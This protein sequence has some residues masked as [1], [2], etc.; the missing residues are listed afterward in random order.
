MISRCFQKHQS[1]KKGESFPPI[2]KRFSFYHRCPSWFKGRRWQF[3]FLCAWDLLRGVK[4]GG[5]WSESPSHWLF[6]YVKPFN[7]A[8]QRYHETYFTSQLMPPGGISSRLRG[9]PRC[10]HVPSFGINAQLGSNPRLSS[11]N[12]SWLFLAGAPRIPTILSFSGAFDPCRC[13][14]LSFFRSGV[15]VSNRTKPLKTLQQH[16]RQPTKWRTVSLPAASHCSNSPGMTWLNMRGNVAQY[17]SSSSQNLIHIWENISSV[18]FTSNY[19][20]CLASRTGMWTD[21]TRSVVAWISLGSAGG[22]K[23]CRLRSGTE[24]EEGVMSSYLVVY[25]TVKE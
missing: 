16:G 24:R 14:K 2:N 3:V 21:K 6:L 9:L 23:R 8:L 12:T 5:H 25:V 13:S 4:S 11:A 20:L 10:T 22:R 18:A 19:R 7:V 1:V 15:S 17:V